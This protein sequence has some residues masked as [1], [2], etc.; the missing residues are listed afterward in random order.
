VD[1]DEVLSGAIEFVRQCG[2][3]AGLGFATASKV[4]TEILA[5]LEAQGDRA[6]HPVAEALIDEREF[7]SYLRSQLLWWRLGG[8]VPA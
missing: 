2:V 7:T 3:R 6:Q 4:A 8:E 5:A 1:R